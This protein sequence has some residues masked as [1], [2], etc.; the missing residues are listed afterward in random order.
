MR[1]CQRTRCRLFNSGG[2]TRA[3]AGLLLVV[4]DDLGEELAARC[5]CESG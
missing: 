3:K 1:K 4:V 2:E 5:R